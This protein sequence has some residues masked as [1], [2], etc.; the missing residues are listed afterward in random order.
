M[1]EKCE[2]IWGT[3][4]PKKEKVMTK[5]DMINGLTNDYE[6]YLS[7]MSEEELK[8]IVKNNVFTLREALKLDMMGK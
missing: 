6:E 1:F 8:I 2:S 5:D 4:P 7:Q 3:K